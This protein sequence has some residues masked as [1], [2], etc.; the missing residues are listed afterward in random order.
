MRALGLARVVDLFKRLEKFLRARFEVES[1][2]REGFGRRAHSFTSF[3]ID[4][5]QMN[6]IAKSRLIT[7]RYPETGYAFFKTLANSIYQVCDNR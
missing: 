5:E 3:G 7:K 4:T 2:V 1:F 6:R